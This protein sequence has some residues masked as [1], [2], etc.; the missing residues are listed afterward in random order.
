MLENKTAYNNL[1]NGVF[2]FRSTGS[3]FPTSLKTIGEGGILDMRNIVV[4]DKYPI[5]NM[6]LGLNAFRGSTSGFDKF[7]V[8]NCGTIKGSLFYF[9][10]LHKKRLH[11]V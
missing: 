4:N 7:L 11:K 3:S 8:N 2:E 6:K 9:I 5:I 1:Q 10:F